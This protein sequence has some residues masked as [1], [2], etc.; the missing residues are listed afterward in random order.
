MGE[1]GGGGIGGFEEFEQSISR[2]GGSADILIHEQELVQLRMIEGVLWP[3]AG[4]R[5]AERFRSDI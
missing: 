2:R 5:K 3:D 1:V 4:L